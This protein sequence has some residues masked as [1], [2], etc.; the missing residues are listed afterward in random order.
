MT[1]DRRVERRARVVLADDDQDIV[2]MYG[3]ALAAAGFAVRT[4]R[5]GIEA[6][7]CAVTERP[8]IVLLDVQMPRMTGIEVL[9]ELRNTP[10]LNATPVVMVTNVTDDAVRREV[11]LLGAWAWVQKSATTPHELVDIVSA[12]P[13]SVL[14]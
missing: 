1:G 13:S 10:D 12:A 7:A 14:L 5:D 3:L 9:R 8:D 2:D 11:Q 4:A 6:V